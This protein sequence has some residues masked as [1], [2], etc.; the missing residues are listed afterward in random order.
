MLFEWLYRASGQGDT[1]LAGEIF[2]E[3]Y[4]KQGYLRLAA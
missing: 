2:V 4:R 3:L 1:S